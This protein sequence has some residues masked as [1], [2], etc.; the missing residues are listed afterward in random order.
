MIELFAD[1]AGIVLRRDV[2]AA[3][4]DDKALIRALHNGSVLRLRQGAYVLTAIWQAAARTERHGLLSHAVQRQYGDHVALS[5]VSAHLEMGGP[6][7]GLDLTDAHVTHL[8]GR[9]GRRR[10]AKVVHHHGM[11][12]VDD[13]TRTADGWMTAPTR[14]AL[15]TASIAARDPAVAVLD[16][17]LNQ[18]LTTLDQLQRGFERMTCWPNTLHLQMALRLTDPL[19]ESV[20]ESRAR[21]LFRE[22]GIPRPESQFRVLHPSGRLA[23]RVDFAWPDRKAMCEVDGLVKY[24]GRRRPGETIEQTVIR[25]KRREDLLRELTGWTMIRLIWADLDVPR[26]TGARMRQFL[27]IAA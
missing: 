18:E 15:D 27:R 1:A 16:W 23:G 7:W 14:T 12:V 24:L 11:C 5:H 19:S 3:L 8:D 26:S 9:G 22:Q 21:L 20:A 10:S 4:G 6:D 2:V 17:H 25:E 13:V